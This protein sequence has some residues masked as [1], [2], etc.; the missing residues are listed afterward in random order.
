MA[1]HTTAA[2]GFLVVCVLTAAGLVALI[3]LWLEQSPVQRL[4]QLQRLAQVEHLATLPPLRLQEQAVWLVQQRSQQLGQMAWL[5]GATGL[6]GLMEGWLWRRQALWG[7]VSLW[8]WRLGGLTLGVLSTSALAVLLVP[9]PLPSLGVACGLAGLSGLGMYW[10][11]A[12]RPY[13]P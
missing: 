4:L 12:G 1:R 6:I 11:A 10:V 13:L 5:I 7:G 3:G 8:R 2:S 9:W